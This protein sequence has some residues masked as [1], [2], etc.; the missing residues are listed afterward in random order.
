MAEI[1]AVLVGKLRELTGER[2]MDCKKALADT[3]ADAEK[4]E[5]AW[6]EA[7]QAHLRKKGLD[8]GSA[9]GSKAAAEGLLGSKRAA[10]GHAVTVVEVT[11]NTDFVAKNEEFLTLLQKLVDLADQHKADSAEKL[12]ALTLD[13]EPV[14]DIV[15]ALAGKIGENIGLKRVVRFEGEVGCYIHFDNKQGALVELSGVTGEAAQKLGKEICMHIVAAKPPPVY[16]TRGEVS[17]EIIKKET[18]IITERL[19]SD[20]KNAAKPPQILEKIA[21]GQLNKFYAEQVLLDQPYAMDNS[22]S[23]TQVLAENG[24]AK[25]VRFARFHVGVI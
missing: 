20:P 6:V 14:A 22:K 11:A 1:T 21:S 5:T 18:D 16:L 4:G 13:G 25:I 3:A 12:S 24:N 23:I 17:A 7:A 8:K 2:L 15:R 19:K 9:M 10:D